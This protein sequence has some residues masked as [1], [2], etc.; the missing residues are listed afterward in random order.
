MSKKL[1]SKK[2]IRNHMLYLII[3]VS[4]IVAGI[5]IG[6]SITGLADINISEE[7]S[8]KYYTSITVEKG[9]TLWSIASKYMSSEYDQIED[10]IT[11]VRS[12]NHLYDNGISAGECLTIPYYSPEML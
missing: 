6:S 5:L 1:L 2:S 3:T 7:A 8:Y 12:L 9:D 10:Y 11:E 4:F